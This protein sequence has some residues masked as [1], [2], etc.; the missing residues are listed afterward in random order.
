MVTCNTKEFAS[1]VSIDRANQVRIKHKRTFKHANRDYF[2]AFKLFS[3]SLA[4]L[5]YFLLDLF[6]RDI[7]FQTEVCHGGSFQKNTSQ[8]LHKRVV[9]DLSEATTT[10]Y[11]VVLF[12]KTFFLIPK[13]SWGCI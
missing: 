7:R 12:V 1:D 10:G 2:F 13:L 8:K 11:D 5:F 9:H 3:Q 6:F 4:K